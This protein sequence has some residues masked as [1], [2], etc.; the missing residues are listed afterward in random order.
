MP[1]PYSY[2]LRQ[3]VMKHYELHGCATLTS[4][5]F[6]ISRGIIYHWKKLK[7]ATGD[8]KPKENYQRGHG[9]KIEDLA[10]FK[11]MV[12]ANA[13]LTLEKLTEK[14]GIDMSIMTCSRALK[15]LNITRKKRP[16]DLKNVM[17]K[18]DGHF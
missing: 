8:I 18:K 3:R 7:E 5:V 12:K 14:S 9:H 2:D 15:K 6:N 1:V 16:M 10:T 17:K 13:G 11:E 4:Q